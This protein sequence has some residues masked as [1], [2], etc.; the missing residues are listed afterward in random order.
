MVDLVTVLTIIHEC[1][2]LAEKML[3]PYD[4]AQYCAGWYQYTLDNYF[5][6]NY[7]NYRIMYQE[8]VRMYDAGEI[9]PPY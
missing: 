5:G 2:L 9:P 3:L 4:F 6:G 1:N 8:F 7:D